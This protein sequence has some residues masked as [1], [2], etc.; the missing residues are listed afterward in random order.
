LDPLAVLRHNFDA[1]QARDFDAVLQN[2]DEDWRYSP[3]PWAPA[4]VHY[5]GHDGYRSMLAAGGWRDAQSFKMDVE[6]SRVDRY[7]MATG[8]AEITT[9]GGERRAHPTTTI[10]LVHDG[11]LQVS[12]GF[13]DEG[14]ARDA[15]A[16]TADEEF[17]LAFNAA[18]D[19]MALLDDEGRIV[20]GN[21]ATAALLGLPQSELRGVRIDRFAPADSR[22]RTLGV[23]ERLKREGQ[24]SGVG[25]LLAADGSRRVVEFRAATNYVAGRHLIIAR[26]RDR[27][28]RAQVGDGGVLT[29]R[30]R[31]VLS[32]LAF[33]LNGP[34]AA[35]RLFL[36]PATVRTHVQNAM[37]ALGAK[38]RA[39]AVAEAL[40]Q[41]ELELNPPSRPQRPSPP[42]RRELSDPS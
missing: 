9:A 39:Q 1:F 20:H 22:E 21:R 24:V 29:P 3:G 42:G 40:I 14:E 10:H 4:G 17:K 33:G 23:W 34:E 2:V 38:T 30:Q 13:A 6:L 11:R 18:P 35:S 19:A 16:L 26:S 15:I 27:G 31:E 28:G 37:Q 32:M 5:H 36:S 7:V 12:R 25:A 41:G 8:V